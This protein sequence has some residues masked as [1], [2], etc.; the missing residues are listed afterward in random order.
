V[1]TADELQEGIQQELVALAEQGSLA[2]KRHL[3]ARDAVLSFWPVGALGAFAGASAPTGAPTDTREEPSP[4]ERARLALQTRLDARVQ[5]LASFQR[6]LKDDPE[7]LRFVDAMLSNHVG[8][9]EKRQQER[10]HTALQEQAASY[11]AL[12]HKQQADAKAGSRRQNVFSVAAAV[13]SLIAGWLLS[14]L[15]PVF[16]LAHLLPH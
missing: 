6:Q 11:E 5:F 16:A 1:A 3:A 10:L 15:N 12:L 8:A 2:A 7:A 9:A 13:V 4:E 14:A